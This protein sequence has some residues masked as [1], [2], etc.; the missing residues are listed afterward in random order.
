[1]TGCDSS[2]GCVLMADFL[3]AKSMTVAKTRV[4]TNDYAFE[5]GYLCTTG[6]ASIRRRARGMLHSLKN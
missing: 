5:D 1:M 3:S 4:N 6:A 2:N